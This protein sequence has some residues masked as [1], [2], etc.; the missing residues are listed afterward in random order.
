[1]QTRQI[2]MIL[3]PI[4]A[5]SLI[6]YAAFEQ[7]RQDSAFPPALVKAMD[8]SVDQAPE[9]MAEVATQAPAGSLQAKEEWERDT[10]LAYARISAEE[11]S[12]VQ[13]KLEDVFFT[14]SG[15][16]ILGDA[17]RRTFGEEEG[18]FLRRVPSLP[19]EEAK[20]ALE[21]RARV[22]GQDYGDLTMALGLST[23][24]IS[25]SEVE[26]LVNRGTMLPLTAPVQ[27]AKQGNLEAL[28]Q[29]VEKGIIGDINAQTPWDGKSALGALIQQGIR[30]RGQDAEIKTADAVQRVIALG[31]AVKLQHGGFDP[32]DYALSATR[33]TARNKLVAAKVLLES[34]API[35]QSHR[36]ALEAMPPGEMRDQFTQLFTPYL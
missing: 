28:E 23:G 33:F 4:V 32:L 9:G 16:D 18:T 6:G 5:L 13:A 19:W 25:A 36:E 30:Y 17:Y 35:E 22:T 29:L 7:G 1:M 2:I 11:I 26:A 3:A 21:A 34:G 27:L 8:I 12:A 14:E 15:K 20:A 24:D 10:T 31:A